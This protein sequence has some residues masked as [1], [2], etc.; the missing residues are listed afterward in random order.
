MALE[1]P[2]VMPRLLAATT[3]MGTAWQQHLDHWEDEEP[4]ECND[5]AIVAHHLVR[6]AAN[7]YQTEFRSIFHA[8]EEMMAEDPSN[9][10]MNL[11][12]VGLLE[13]LQN[14]TSWPQSPVGSS[15]FLPYASPSRPI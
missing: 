12:A 4:G 13:D 6:L 11:L 5:I 14:I 3:T 7:K 10:V 8:V 1:V 2:E 15:A 9:E